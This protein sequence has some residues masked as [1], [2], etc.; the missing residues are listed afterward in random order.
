MKS[1]SIAREEIIKTTVEAD[2]IPLLLRNAKEGI[3]EKTRLIQK[4]PNKA[5]LFGGKKQ[6]YMSSSSLVIPDLEGFFILPR[7][8]TKIVLKIV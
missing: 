3:E 5:S 1:L 7:G 4:N 2:G 8:E 6:L